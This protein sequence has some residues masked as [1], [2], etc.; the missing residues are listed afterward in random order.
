MPYSGVSHFGAGMSTCQ[1]VGARQELSGKRDSNW[2][3]LPQDAEKTIPQP[4]E[5][6][7][8]VSRG[9]ASIHDQASKFTVSK[10]ATSQSVWPARAGRFHPDHGGSPAHLSLPVLDHIRSVRGETTSL[11]ADGHNA[12]S[13]TTGTAAYQPVTHRPR[14]SGSD[15]VAAPR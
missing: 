11:P 3:T 5:H 13:L 12:W 8:E 4:P 2:P 10:P 6:Y 7:S 15:E 14:G 9:H 1:S